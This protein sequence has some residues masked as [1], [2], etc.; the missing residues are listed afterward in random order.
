MNLC[1]LNKLSWQEVFWE[2]G[3]NEKFKVFMDL[4]LYY[5]DIAFPLKFRHRKIS[6][7]NG[8][9]TQGIK[10]SSKRMRFL[11]VLKKQPN[12]SEET[13]M[14][15]DN[16]KIIYK[17]V[18]RGAKRRANNKYIL[19]AKHKSKAIWQI[20]NKETG[21]NLSNKS[22]IT[23]NW[24]SE[25]ITHPENVAELFNTYFSN[26]SE[27]LLKK[28]GKSRFHPPNQ[29]LKIKEITKT[30]FLFLG[31]ESEVEKVANDL[32]NKLSAG[33]DDIPDYVVKRCIQV[34]KK[35]LQTFIMRP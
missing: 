32:K 7:R 21:K 34:L 5:F 4:V 14:Y 25:E 12:L 15:I 27:E 20:I 11:N 19:H 10:K 18:F 28:N 30:M 3:V 9:I 24:N 1:L 2:T 35:P 33:I 26:I 31:T 6:S 22:D 8:W 29:H 16:Y 23:I 17:T 13:K